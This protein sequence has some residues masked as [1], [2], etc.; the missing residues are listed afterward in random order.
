MLG[1]VLGASLVEVEIQL[2]TGNVLLSSRKAE[3]SESAAPV[4][5][6]YYVETDPLAKQSFSLTLPE[7]TGNFLIVLQQALVPL[8][9][10]SAVHIYPGSTEPAGVPQL[11]SG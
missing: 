6:Y 2:E 7:S 9:S 4:T 8:Q 5:S 10:A 11:L 3:K 1:V